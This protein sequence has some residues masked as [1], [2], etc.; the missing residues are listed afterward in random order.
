MLLTCVAFWCFIAAC[1][2]GF[3]CA[4]AGFGASLYFVASTSI[5]VS[6]TL[7]LTQHLSRLDEP[8]L[9]T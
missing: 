2:T 6:R 7:T 4:G 3:A 5:R 1:I 8:V 9:T